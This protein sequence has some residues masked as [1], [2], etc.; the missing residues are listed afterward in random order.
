MLLKDEQWKPQLRAVEH[1]L[2]VQH[3]FGEA[4]VKRY[5]RGVQRV[6]EIVEAPEHSYFLSVPRNTQRPPRKGQAISCYVS[7]VGFVFGVLVVITYR[8]TFKDWFVVAYNKGISL[9]AA[10]GRAAVD[11]AVKLATRFKV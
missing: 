9:P 11:I 10:N 3:G 8:P 6:E 7:T 4:E 5:T 1:A 2:C